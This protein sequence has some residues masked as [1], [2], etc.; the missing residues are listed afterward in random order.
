MAAISGLQ[1]SVTATRVE[2]IS[3]IIK[4]LE[5]ISCDLCEGKLASYDVYMESDI[6]NVSFL[7][8]YC[9]DCIQKVIRQ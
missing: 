8:R 6:A 1:Y 4:A 2:P 3:D 5:V 7:K 9:S